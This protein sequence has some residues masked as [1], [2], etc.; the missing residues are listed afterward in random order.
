MPALLA[1]VDW[2]TLL[3]GS[4]RTVLERHA[5]RPFLERQRWFGQ[6]MREIRRVRFADWV[7][8]TSGIEPAFLTFVTVQY[9]D[10]DLEQ[11]AVPLA[12]L[13][14]AKAERAIA[15]APAAVLARMTGARKGAIV[16]GMN[17]DATCERL[18]ALVVNG[19]EA[20]TPAGAVHGALIAATVAG[21]VTTPGT[22]KWTRYQGDGNNSVASVDEKHVLKL[23]RRLEE[24]PH[25][26]LEIEQALAERGFPRVAPLLGSISYRKSGVESTT[27]A[28][29]QAHVTHQGT[30]WE[31]TVNEARRFFERVSTQPPPADEALLA[32][33]PAS[34]LAFQ[35]WFLRS[36]GLLGRRTAEL[37]LTLIGTP[38]AEFFPEAFD[39]AARDSFA[40]D[41]RAHAEATLELLRS[42]QSTLPDAAAP[43]AAALLGARDRVLALADTLCKIGDRGQR[44]RIHGDYHLGQVLRVEEDFVILDFEGEPARTQR[45]RRAKQSPLRDVAG[46]VRSFG[47]ATST[48]LFA[49]TLDAP[50]AYA[51]L[52]PWSAAWQ[53]W[54]TET[55]VQE[56]R[57]TM[58]VSPAVTAGDSFSRMLRIFVFDRGLHE[59]TYDLQH[60]P[61]QA[62]VSLTGLLKMLP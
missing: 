26:E 17:D 5:L 7:R 45:E 24:G 40:G 12:L 32:D 20:S 19:E 22:G 42:R 28:L 27:V 25:P 57:A 6:K 49:S 55:F 38:R 43:H 29:V 41:M 11:Y 60:R 10:G 34:V 39:E 53:R 21:D 18:L 59:L 13:S 52:E 54:V 14:G 61:E 62:W 44:I 46:M 31:Y 51:T 16:D 48:T 37:H 15:E 30:A 23:I 33:A 9:A 47:Y 1:G 36:V 8:L 3:D 56:Y 35:R 50:D 58:G 2:Q 4:M